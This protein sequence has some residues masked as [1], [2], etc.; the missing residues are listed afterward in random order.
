MFSKF[1]CNLAQGCF[2]GK[3]CLDHDTVIDGKSCIF[4]HDS[5][6]PEARPG[7]DNYTIKSNQERSSW[8]DEKHDRCGWRG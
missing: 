8:A 4:I 6:F 7:Q 3:L 1:D 5:S 2:F